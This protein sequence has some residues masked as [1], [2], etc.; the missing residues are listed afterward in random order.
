M[1]STD[2]VAMILYVVSLQPITLKAPC[3]EGA[4][5]ENVLEGSD[6]APASLL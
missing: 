6:C 4:T 3:W 5:F 1:F 2:L